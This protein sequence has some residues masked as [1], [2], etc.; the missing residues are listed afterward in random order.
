M[1]GLELVV[2]KNF[3]LGRFQIAK[4][5]TLSCC[6]LWLVCSQLFKE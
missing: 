2:P 6:N 4:F 1:D 3:E 5:V